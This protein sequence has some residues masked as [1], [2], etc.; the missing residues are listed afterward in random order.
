MA[1]LAAAQCAAQLRKSGRRWLAVPPLAGRAAGRR[2]LAA[3]YGAPSKDLRAL[4]A[5]P[6]NFGDAMPLATGLRC[7]KKIPI[8]PRLVEGVS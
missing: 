5:N 1:P 7:P 2:W 4:A 6:A 8:Q 3:R